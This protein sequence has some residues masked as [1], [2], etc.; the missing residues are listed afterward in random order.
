MNISINF[1]KKT[2]DNQNANST[3]SQWEILVEQIIKGNV[4][5]VIGSRLTMCDGESISDIL[6]RNISRY[7]NKQTP[8]RSFSQLTP[9]FQV[10][11]ENESIFSFVS[12]ILSDPQ[13]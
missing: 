13:N 4:I 8:A 3:E 9:R 5:P 6:V 1:G 2:S 10:E 7:C 12:D 11:H